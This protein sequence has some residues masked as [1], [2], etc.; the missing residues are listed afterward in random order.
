ML[1]VV[2]GLTMIHCSTVMQVHCL[3]LSMVCSPGGG[4]MEVMARLL[5]SGGFSQTVADDFAHQKSA[6]EYICTELREADEANLLQEEDMH[7]Y[8][9]SPMTDALQLVCCNNCK[10]PIKDSQFAAHTELCRSLKLTEQ[11]TFELDG[12]T[13]SRKPPRKEKKKLAASCANQASAVGEQRRSG[14]M[15]NIDSDLSQS[16]RISQIRV[17]PFSNK[18]KGHSTCVDGASMMDGTGI[19]PGNRDHPA[20]IMHPPTKR[21]KLRA[22]TSLPVLESP[23]TDSVETKTLS[24]TDGISCKDLV[25]I[26]TSEHGDPNRKILGQVL[27]Q[28]PNTTKNEFPAPL[29]TKI[30]YSQR[31]NRLRARLRHLY[32]QNLN[33]Q[34]RTDLCPKTS[35]AEMV[36]FQDSSLRC[37]SSSQMDNVHEGRSPQKSDHILAKSSEVCILKAGGLPSSGLSNQFLLDNVSRSTATHVGLTRS[38]FLPTS[39]SFSSNTGNS[40]G[41]MQ[42]PNGSVPVI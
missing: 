20:S 23:V 29:A 14:S 32:F 22:N 41:T 28:P 26:T 4:R 6:A 1:S 12:S 7:V 31:T 38:N 10:K 27:V 11:T 37:P 35:H 33:E 2:L 25:E 40:L 36:T 15:D 30:F 3:L 18:V 21:H 16:H 9:V 34:L 24:F 8:G 39:Y 42:Q 17:I 13:G 19:N 5:A